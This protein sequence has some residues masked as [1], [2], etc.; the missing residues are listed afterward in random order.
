MFV[1]GEKVNLRPIMSAD[2]NKIIEWSNNKQL[3]SY[4]GQRL[5]TSYPECQKRYL[6]T[7][8][9][10][11]KSLAIENKKGELIGE[12]DLDHIQWRNRQGEIFI[13]IGEEKLWGKGY[14]FD[15]LKT[16][17]NNFLEK[18]GFKYIYLRVYENNK[19]A[20]SC[21]EKF[22]FKKRGILKFNKN[23]LHN[24]NLILMDLNL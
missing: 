9:L 15:A 1:D 17:I 22:G 20:I 18:K 23:S 24:K 21:Y 6:E 2:F 14:G 13:Y 4:M 8:Q 3:L 11:N 16:F 19:R 7:S 5:P 10:L 12:I